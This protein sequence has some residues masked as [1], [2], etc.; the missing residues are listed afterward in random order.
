MLRL[1]TT[2]GIIIATL[3]AACGQ[4]GSGSDTAVRFR[5]REVRGRQ[6]M[7][8][9]AGRYEGELHL[10]IQGTSRVQGMQNYG[11]QWS[12]D[13]HLLWDGVVGDTMA[14]SFEVDVAGTYDIAVQLTVA[15]DYGRFD[16]SLN[17]QPAL[18]GID[19]YGPR[20][21]LAPL[22]TIKNVSLKSGRQSLAFRLTGS[23]PQARRFRNRGYL[24]G[25]DYVQ[26]T[27]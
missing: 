14:T 9:S 3:T 1:L 24:L 16:L 23:D 15:G 17:G 26:L 7:S 22:Q 18:R 5:F 10:E 25:L 4:N 6:A 2:I 20:V 13:A 8:S 27:G 19:L 21:A 12:G 11:K